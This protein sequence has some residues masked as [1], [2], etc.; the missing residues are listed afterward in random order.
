MCQVHSKLGQGAH[1]ETTVN[2]QALGDKLTA[3]SQSC[4]HLVA[5]ECWDLVDHNLAFE[6]TLELQQ[7]NGAVKS[8]E[9]TVW[10]AG[11]FAIKRVVLGQIERDCVTEHLGV[12][13]P[14]NKGSSEWLE[15]PSPS[16]SNV[17]AQV[18]WS[19]QLLANQACW[20]VKAPVKTAISEAPMVCFLAL[21]QAL[22][23]CSNPVWRSFKKALKALTLADMLSAYQVEVFLQLGSVSG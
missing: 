9:I 11:Y 20:G 3:E 21:T 19:A 6:R 14:L 12:V 7:D 18:V 4:L 8:L 15:E 17:V 23:R 5:V 22:L 16:T 10:A 2:K 13:L 1:P